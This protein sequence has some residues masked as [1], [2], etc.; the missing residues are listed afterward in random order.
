MITALLSQSNL[1]CLSFMCVCVSF[2]QLVL[3]QNTHMP[4]LAQVGSGLLQ[5]HSAEPQS[6]LFS[7]SCSVSVARKEAAF[8]GTFRNGILHVMRPFN[9]HRPYARLF[10]ALLSGKRSQTRPDSKIRSIYLRNL[11]RENSEL[12]IH[13]PTQCCLKQL[14]H[15]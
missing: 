8:P 7:V 10:R 5:K 13:T 9:L 11:G 15:D 6:Q 1:L 4:P 3:L 14:C 12:L 2:K